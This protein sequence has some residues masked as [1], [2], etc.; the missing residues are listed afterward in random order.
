M[1][2]IEIFEWSLVSLLICHGIQLFWFIDIKGV[3]THKKVKN[4]ENHAVKKK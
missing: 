2:S 4:S 3:K 1:R